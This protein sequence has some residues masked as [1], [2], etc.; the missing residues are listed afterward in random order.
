MTEG[1]SMEWQWLLVFQNLYSA[2]NMSSLW[3][4]WLSHEVKQKL[5]WAMEHYDGT[6]DNNCWPW[7]LSR[8]VLDCFCWLYQDRYLWDIKV[9]NSSL[10]YLILYKYYSPFNSYSRCD[11]QQ[12]MRTEHKIVK[13]N[14]RY[15]GSDHDYT[16]ATVISFYCI[17]IIIIE[18][19]LSMYYYYNYYWAI[20]LYIL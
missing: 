1:N 11:D 19:S 7:A 4:Y 12:N 3:W 6:G 18:L 10:S 15:Y 5:H 17:S 2:T 14:I 13:I 9:T 20:S 16:L 8:R